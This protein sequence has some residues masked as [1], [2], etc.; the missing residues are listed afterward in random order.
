M[1]FEV[2]PET[3]KAVKL[4][5]GSV[6]GVIVLFAIRPVK[7]WLIRSIAAFLFAMVLGE[8]IMEHYAIPDSWRMGMGASLAIVGLYIAS[9]AVYVFENFNYEEFIKLFLPGPKK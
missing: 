1:A 8:P 3:A 6:V 7:A 2:D 9:G 4:A 5:F